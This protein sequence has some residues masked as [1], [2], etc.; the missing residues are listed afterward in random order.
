MTHV[1]NITDRMT[2]AERAARLSAELAVLWDKYPEPRQI[3]T[4]ANDDTI[5]FVI[6]PGIAIIDRD[7]GDETDERRV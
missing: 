2:D 5:V 4:V 6:A 3:G 1:H 7:P